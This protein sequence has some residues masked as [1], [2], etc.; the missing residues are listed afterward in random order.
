ME[1]LTFVFIACWSNSEI[2]KIVVPLKDTFLQGMEL[3]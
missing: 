3:H 1:S 2:K